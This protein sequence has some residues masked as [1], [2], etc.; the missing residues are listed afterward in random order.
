MKSSPQYS[1][2]WFEEFLTVKTGEYF[3]KEGERT[4]TRD[5]SDLV[6]WGGA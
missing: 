2:D 6:S 1:S 4:A 3:V 5:L